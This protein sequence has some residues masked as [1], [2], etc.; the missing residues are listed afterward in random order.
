MNSSRE[1]MIEALV[2]QV[3]RILAVA[4][5]EGIPGLEVRSR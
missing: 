4:C 2:E 5:A 3:E 1:V